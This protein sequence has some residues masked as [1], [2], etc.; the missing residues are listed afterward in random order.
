MQE[1][2]RGERRN[3][4]RKRDRR[5]QERK[6]EERG[7]ERKEN[8]NATNK[9]IKKHSKLLHL[10]MN[11][12]TGAAVLCFPLSVTFS[13]KEVSTEPSGR[14]AVMVTGMAC[15]LCAV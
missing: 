1:N 11:I 15:C 2:D 9:Q 8:L 7:S 3:R 10:I 13:E 14:R 4:K 6:K 5:E 12:C